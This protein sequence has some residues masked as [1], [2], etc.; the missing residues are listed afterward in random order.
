[1][2]HQSKRCGYL[3]NA[4]ALTQCLS[5]VSAVSAQPSD[6]LPASQSEPPA[7]STIHLSATTI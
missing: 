6:V 3:S 5:S 7:G 1:M 2:K 4:L